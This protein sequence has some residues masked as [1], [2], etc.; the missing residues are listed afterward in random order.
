VRFNAGV[1]VERAGGND[2]DAV[3]G[4]D[5]RHQAPTQAA[6]YRCES[7][8]IGNLVAREMLF[9]SGPRNR[10]RLH[11]D[12]ARMARTGRF[13]ATLT[14]AV[15]EMHRFTAD[16]VAY[17]STQTTAGQIQFAHI[18]PRFECRS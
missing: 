8:R 5:A 7:F 10:R 15:K 4:R 2:C 16:L 12:I 13:T 6:E 1:R 17:G 14:V 3:V 9:A 18:A 11:N